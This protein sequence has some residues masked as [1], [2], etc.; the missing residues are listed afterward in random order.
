MQSDLKQPAIVT[1]ETFANFK[2]ANCCIVWEFKGNWHRYS[3]LQTQVSPFQPL[4]GTRVVVSFSGCVAMRCSTGEFAWCSAHT[5]NAHL[6]QCGVTCEQPWQENAQLLTSNGLLFW[7]LRTSLNTPLH[8]RILSVVTTG[9]SCIQTY[10]WI[11]N[12][13]LIVSCDKFCLSFTNTWWKG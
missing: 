11:R 5:A 4:Y 1:K 9:Y 10:L 12:T 7:Q 2:K 8:W 3:L 6:L 13:F